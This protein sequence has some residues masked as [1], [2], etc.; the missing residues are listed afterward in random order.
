MDYG[1][2]IGGMLEWLFR[3]AIVGVIA[4][5]GTALWGLYQIGS[6]IIGAVF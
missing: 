5:A 3:L 6:F 2:A 4:I 1:N